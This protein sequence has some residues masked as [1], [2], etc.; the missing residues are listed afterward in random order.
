MRIGAPVPGIYNPSFNPLQGRK[1]RRSHALGPAFD[2]LGLGNDLLMWWDTGTLEQGTVA[3]WT[4]RKQNRA[5]ILTGTGEAVSFDGQMVKITSTSWLYGASAGNGL[6]PPYEIW[7]VV[8]QQETGGSGHRTSFATGAGASQVQLEYTADIGGQSSANIG[9]T[10]IFGGDAYHGVHVIRWQIGASGGYCL[11][12][13][14]RKYGQPAYISPAPTIS[15]NSV[16]IGRDTQGAGA[17]LGRIGDIVITKPLSSA[18]VDGMWDFM[19]K[20]AGLQA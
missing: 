6:T 11:G 7:Q 3:S 14:D 15:P 5:L 19:A 2:P 16:Y 4:D 8:D 18:E 9:G 12:W 10:T 20:R 1:G 17:W 13:V